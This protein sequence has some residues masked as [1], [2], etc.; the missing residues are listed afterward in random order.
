MYVDAFVAC[1][2]ERFIFC[3]YTNNDRKLLSAN[4]V[5]PTS[6]YKESDYKLA[7]G[8]NYIFWIHVFEL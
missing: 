3:R 7:T 2:H 8:T 1:C 4:Q 6:Y 5:A